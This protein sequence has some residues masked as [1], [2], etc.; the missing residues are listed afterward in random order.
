MFKSGKIIVQILL[1]IAILA[2]GV[3]IFKL[4]ASMKKP[5]EKKGHKILAPLVETMDVSAGDSL[6]VVRSFGTVTAKTEVQVVPQVSGQIIACHNDFVNGGFFKK[7]E[8]LIT[9]DPRDYQLIVENAEAAV[10][11]AQVALDQETAEAAVALNEW[12][13]L[14]TGDKP[15]SDLVLRKPQIRQA[16]AELKAA[17][18]QLEKARLDLERTKLSLP[19]DGRVSERNVDIGQYVMAGQPM[20]SVYSTQAVEIVVPLEDR[21]LAWFDIPLGYVN[22]NGG[23][24][25]TA[26]SKVLITAKFAGAEHTWTGVVVRTEGKID[27]TSRMVNVVVEIANPFKLTNGKPPL[28]PGMFVDVQITGKQLSNVIKVPRFALHNKTQLWLV[29]DSR[30]HIQQV[31][32]TRQDDEFAYITDGLEPGQTIVISPLDMVT[33][34]MNIRTQRSDEPKQAEADAP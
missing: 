33:E 27:P 31:T 9:I 18:A 21:E 5:P 26:G 8:P 25:S 19:F 3:G 24:I 20:A 11:R 4:L 16:N 1:V 10:A 29:N 13:Q 34:N 17:G 15:P 28:V 30:L 12:Q 2:I 14:N 32:V 22:G 6:M 7:G 23:E